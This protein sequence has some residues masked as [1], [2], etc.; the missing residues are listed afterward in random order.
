MSTPLDYCP[1]FDQFRHLK[2]FSRNCSSCCGELEI[3]S[4]EVDKPHGCIQ[5]GSAVG[6]S[7]CTPSG[8]P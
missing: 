4:D 2:S 3:F 7:A 6:F 5:C 8:S 1:G